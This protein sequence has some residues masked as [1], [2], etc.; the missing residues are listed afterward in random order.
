VRLR[1][2]RFDSAPSKTCS[3]RT[4]RARRPLSHH[5]QNDIGKE[6]KEAAEAGVR[7][8]TASVPHR[9]DDVVRSNTELRGRVTNIDMSY[10]KEPELEQIPYLGFRELNAD[11]APEVVRR[12]TQEAF[13]SPQL[14][15]AICLNLCDG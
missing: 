14:M 9:S 6:I 12:L 10:W 13:G 1:N 7:I 4:L 2:V 3:G 11:I 8:V 15:Q 5:R